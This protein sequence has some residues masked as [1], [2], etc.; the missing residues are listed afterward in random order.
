MELIENVRTVI[1]GSGVSGISSAL[2]LLKN[3]HDE[4]LIIEA[5][6][7]IGGRCFTSEIG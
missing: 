7:R 3:G 1:V 4:F 2:N 5:M 6:N